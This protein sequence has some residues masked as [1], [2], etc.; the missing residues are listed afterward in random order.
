MIGLVPKNWDTEEEETEAGGGRPS[1]R[2]EPEEESVLFP[3]PLKLQSEEEQEPVNLR[4]SAA[5]LLWLSAN[6]SSVFFAQ[7]RG[8]WNGYVYRY[9]DINYFE[10]RH[11]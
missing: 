3:E 11:L 6:G 10:L 7:S 9:N 4:V 8:A 2:N 1:N 5:I